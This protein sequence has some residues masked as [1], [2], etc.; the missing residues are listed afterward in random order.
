MSLIQEALKRQ[1]EELKKK[2]EQETE[3]PQEQVSTDTVPPKLRVR[4]TETDEAVAK[5][6][7]EPVEQPPSETEVPPESETTPSEKRPR[8]LW[9]EGIIIGIVVIILLVGLGWAVYHLL[10]RT[11]TP[12]KVTTVPHP[13]GVEPKT[14]TRPLPTVTEKTSLATSTTTVTHVVSS[15]D[16]QTVQTTGKTSETV[17]VSS[18]PKTVARPITTP[19]TTVMIIPSEAGTSVITKKMVPWPVLKLSGVV[20]KGTRGSAIINGNIVLIG[21]TIDGVKV[22]K[23]IEGGV[24]VEYQGETKFLRVG[25]S[26]R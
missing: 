7:Q 19:E 13:T 16:L 4:P 2:T 11:K 22:V 14:G 25:G 6:A 17:S 21:Q 5:R 20:G 3:T 10:F 8:R 12:E 1:Q 23:I 15:Q 24:E 18:E 9:I 26:S